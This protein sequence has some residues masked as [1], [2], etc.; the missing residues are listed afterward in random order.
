MEQTPSI[1]CQQNPP[2]ALLEPTYLLQT[3]SDQHLRRGLPILFHQR[4]QQR[5]IEST[6]SDNRAI[7]LEHDTVLLAPFH[8]VWTA[9]PRM[10]FPLPYTYF[11][12]LAFAISTFEL[13][14]V[15]LEL[16]EMVDA[17]V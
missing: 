1:P 7:R 8:D 11:T 16:I 13:L 6:T 9:E 4:L 14:D 2:E 3:P 5:V 12:T 15:C 17:V 10:Q